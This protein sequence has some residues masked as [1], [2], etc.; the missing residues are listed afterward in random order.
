MGFEE[1]YYSLLSSIFGP[2]ISL[3]ESLAIFILSVIVVFLI[4]II[5]RFTQDKEKLK[6]IREQQK[7]KQAKMKELQ[8]TNPE[9]ANKMASEMFKLNN[10]QLRANMKPLLLTFIIVFALLPWISSVFKGPVVS[11]PVSL[12][13]LGNEIDWLWWY[14]IISIPLNTIFRKLLDVI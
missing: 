2:I 1:S 9:E 7:E 8:K 13:F 6:S 4:T 5:Y 3:Q 12:P 10:E 14:L 11:L